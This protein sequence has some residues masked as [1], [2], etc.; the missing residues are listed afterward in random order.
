M[1][2]NRLSKVCPIVAVSTR[3]PETNATPSMTATPVRRNLILRARMPLMVTRHIVLL[4]EAFHA[5]EDGLRGRVRHLVHDPS[6]IEEHRAVRVAG[7][8]RIVRDHDDGLA[9]V[10]DRL[11]H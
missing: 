9:E 5:V 4:S 7:R 3:V 6:V 11:T 1:V 10:L 8:D 2:L